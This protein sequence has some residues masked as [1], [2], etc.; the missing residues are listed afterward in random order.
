MK[1]I[2]KGM[3]LVIC[4]VIM[5]LISLPSFVDSSS[6]GVTINWNVSYP[7]TQ[8]TA[9]GGS[10]ISCYFPLNV[11]SGTYT[12]KVV[13]Y[14]NSPNATINSPSN[15]ATHSYVTY[16][17]YTLFFG[18]R[19]YDSY[20]T[21]QT[22]YIP[23]FN[24]WRCDT[25]GNTY[26]QLIP[27]INMGSTIVDFNNT[28]VFSIPANYGFI[29][30]TQVGYW[31]YYYAQGLVH[32][33]P[34]SG[35][36]IINYRYDDALPNSPGE[37]QITSNYGTKFT[38]YS[39][40][41]T[42]YDTFYYVNTPN[43]SLQWTPAIDGYVDFEG[44]SNYR[45][46]SGIN[47]YKVSL[48]NNVNPTNE[49]FTSGIETNINLTNQPLN[50]NKVFTIKV[51]ARDNEPLNWSGSTQ[52]YGA[53]STQTVG[54]LY[55]DPDSSPILPGSPV[56]TG[57]GKNING[58]TNS[59]NLAW[60]WNPPQNP[61]IGIKQYKYWI[62]A[63]PNNKGN[64]NITTDTTCTYTAPAD[65]TYYCDV[66]AVDYA[67]N[68]SQI[69]TGSVIVDTQVDPV[70]FN[71]YPVQLN[72]A[73]AELIWNPVSDGSGISKYEV[74][75][76]QTTA[77]PVS[78][79]YVS[80]SDLYNQWTYK[81]TDLSSTNTYYAWVRG[82][83][84][85][86]NTG[87]WTQTGPFPNFQFNG[88]ADNLQSTSCAQVFTVQPYSLIAGN[89][90][91]FWVCYYYGLNSGNPAK[92]GPFVSG[93]QTINFPSDGDWHWWLEVSEFK[94]GAEING[95]KQITESYQLSIDTTPP[96]KP[97]LDISP[98]VCAKNTEPTI[99]FSSN[100]SGSGLNHYELS[101]DSGEFSTVLSPYTLPAQ[102]EGIHNIKVR[103][104][105]NAGLTSVE[106]SATVVFDL[107]PPG[108][109]LQFQHTINNNQITIHWQGA[110]P[111]DDLLKFV[112]SYTPPFGIGTVKTDVN[113]IIRD[114]VKTGDFNIQLTGYA[115][116]QPVTIEVYSVD[117]AGNPSSTASYTA[118]TP[119]E[120][121]KLTFL[122]V[123]Y[124]PTTGHHLK[125][126]VDSTPGQAQSY[127]LEY[128][129]ITDGKFSVL[130]RVNSDSA[131]LI[132]HNALVD[133]SKLQPHAIY[134][135]RLVSYNNSGDPTY[136]IVFDQQV[137]NIAPNK[138]IIV[139][140]VY[141]GRSDTGFTYNPAADNDGDSNLI[142]TIFVGTGTNPTQFTDLK[143]WDRADFVQGQTYTWYVQVDDQHQDGITQSDRVQFTVDNNP[144]VLKVAEPH[145]PFTNQTQL[146]IA[147]SDDLSGI[148]QVTWQKID[149]I[150]NLQIATGT[151]DLTPGND[152]ALTGIIPLEQGNY[153]IL[154]TA[155]DKA[156]N[157]KLVQVNNLTV[158]QVKPVLTGLT[159]NLPQSGGKYISG[160]QK[161]PVVFSGSD[162]F[163]GIGALCYALVKDQSKPLA[164]GALVQLRAGFDNYN[165]RLE[166]NAQL[167]QEYYLAAAILDA[168]G[169]CSEVKYY[170]PILFDLTPPVVDL[171]L[172]GPVK[173][174]TSYY[175]ADLKNLN[176]GLQAGDP[177]TNLIRSQV[178][179]TD[180][181]KTMVTG[182]G[183]WEAI[184]QNTVLISG[185]KY[186]ITVRVENEAGLITQK[187]SPE[188][189]YDNT[190]PEVLSIQG[191]A[192]TV[193]SGEQTVIRIDAGD[194]ESGI[195][196]YR[197]AICLDAPIDYKLT[198]LIS[199]N[200]DGWI[201]IRPGV[202]PQE[203]RLELPTGASGDYYPIIQ[204]T[205][206]AGLT[207]FQ[208]GIK[209]TLIHTAEKIS[210]SDQGPYSMFTDRLSGAWKYLGTSQVTKYHYRITGPD[211]QGVTVWKTTTGTE[212]I[213][214]GLNLKSGTTY[215]FEV[216]AEFSDGSFSGSGFSPGVT[217]DTTTPEAA[218]LVTPECAT[219]DNLRFQ[220][221]GNDPESGIVLVQAALG[222]D[223]YQSD[224]TGGWVTLTGN[225][226]ML[227]CDIHGNTLRL[228]TGKRYYLTLRLTNGAGLTTETFNN[229]II[230]D[231]TPP[232]VPIVFDQGA[233]INPKQPLVAN[234]FWSPAD[235]ESGPDSYQWTLI[236]EGQELNTAVWR[237][238]D[239]SKRI[240]LTE[241]QAK[242]L[243][244]YLEAG[245]TPDGSTFYFAVRA[246]NRAG[247]TSTGI[248]NGIMADST[249]PYI[250]EVKLLNAVNLGDP[251]AAEVNYITDNQNLGLWIRSF[252][253]DTPIDQYL[254]AFGTPETID[255]Q[256]REESYGSQIQLQ[257]PPIHEEEITLFA[258]ECSNKA[259]LVSA[260]GYSSGVVLDTGAPKITNVHGGVSGNRLIFDWDVI[261]SVSPVAF[262]EVALVKSTDANSIPAAWTNIGLKRC[263]TVD[264]TNLADGK[265]CLLIR[266]TNEA[267]TVS[268]RQQDIDEWGISPVVML[269]RT[270][271]VIGDFSY[272][273]Y[274][275]NQLTL[276]ISATDNLAG[277][278]GYQ[279]TIGS[280]GDPF[281]YTGGWIA[282]NSQAGNL[283]YTIDTSLIAHNTS[284]YLMVRTIDKVGLWSKPVI[285]DKIIIDHIKPGI[286]DIT[287][288]QYCISQTDVNGIQITSQDPESGITHYRLGVVSQLGGPWLATQ[289]LPVS[290]FIGQLAGFTLNDGGVYYLAIQAQN[291]A[292]EWS[293]IGYSEAF[294]VDLTNPV[295]TFEKAGETI[296]TNGP[297]LRIQ[298]RLNKP[299][300]VDF[301]LTGANTHKTFTCQGQKDGNK[302][303][304]DE[305]I[306]D[307]SPGLYKLTGRPVAPSGRTGEVEQQ[308]IRVNSPPA[309]EI[310]NFYATPG[311]E[312]HIHAKVTDADGKVGGII[313]YTINPGHGTD[314]IQGEAILQQDAVNGPIYCQ[315]DGVHQYPNTLDPDGQRVYKAILSVSDEDE[316]TLSVTRDVIIQNTTHGKL[317]TDE[318]WFGVHRIN[319]DITVPP[320]I[321]LIVVPGTQVII[322]GIP[323]ETGYNHVLII[324]G[325]L[326]VQT[327]ATFKSITGTVENGWKGIY[328]TGQATLD[329]VN[330][331]HALRGI[332]VMNTA[333][334]MVNN[335]SF[336]D[337]Y[338]GIHV[339]GSK[340]RI[341][342][343]QFTNNQWYGIKEDRGGWPVVTH[344]GFT[345]NE[346]NYYQ[347]QVSEITI[348]DLNRIPGNGGNHDQD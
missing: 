11:N 275:S 257:D 222:S 327:G 8:F 329:G 102:T 48:Y 281:K 46:R 3:L 201:I 175:L 97:N 167:G 31:Y 100:D 347:D 176:I 54:V 127:A 348:D 223:Y 302:F 183:S 59:F 236:R 18:K 204:A 121:G 173:Y 335:C 212:A 80:N 70:T 199:G 15:I 219:S 146:T 323:G 178:A 340:P 303:I 41:G 333:N 84:N 103:A 337:N 273:K 159:V 61:I 75:I 19:S 143:Q 271:P 238:G 259:E 267:G 298:Y 180:S 339:Y 177:E 198:S 235:P 197:L 311:E 216:Q 33:Y 106:A 114:G 130:G 342:H 131:G 95:S 218:S 29:A 53:A 283:S 23:N 300:I 171:E 139:F 158:D 187:W 71:I 12:G 246:A 330:I 72:G 249:A 39:Y 32:N 116:N 172:T 156:N 90:L 155:Y 22:G 1:H 30:K 322:D 160:S 312:L 227:T 179:I 17:R 266:A 243:F 226:L 326:T 34:F 320:G 220:W 184:K 57:N 189:I 182:W 307:L 202:N 319:G 140:P 161:V 181:N 239:D 51:A 191:P 136:G 98:A 82:I 206:G 188:F 150:T 296:V 287:C 44:N 190:P 133:G 213:V 28:G 109:P 211:Q 260:T 162:S 152:G 245:L 274:T 27:Q 252:D 328:I 128:G 164:D 214:T 301:A 56:G 233:Y 86:D 91:R 7:D 132:V 5:L 291:G 52:G 118:Y 254:Y 2:F 153:H 92:Q 101:I 290:E 163:S 299:A 310:S 293:E 313:K 336:T 231:D 110:I 279:Y 135:Y 120:L 232:S 341:D 89:E 221:T 25:S 99:R 43:I 250:P 334:V 295:L 38:N 45:M 185:T 142:Y 166:I 125:W 113:P 73:V 244:P 60:S 138:P 306:W 344:C 117:E 317:W 203:I 67:G 230:I 26:D 129:N 237:D 81:F 224:V 9:S 68:E 24:I 122:G 286:P 55:I 217:I 247:L 272:D 4:I 115:F 282:I 66:A 93:S 332:T 186:L 62:Y 264:G 50:Q 265:Y 240:E 205:N 96:E 229:G 134:Y 288:G 78:G 144:P 314:L 242:E 79:K 16:S 64:C 148:D 256:I 255:T 316:G 47:K 234:W 77:E 85:L 76:T 104:I 87:N 69:K 196:E 65:G 277:I 10:I 193:T 331:Y 63:T 284:I 228:E 112:A 147:A 315:I 37:P 261:P 294:T 289:T 111:D 268:R 124:D 107:T 119:A 94:N 151:I 123:T 225:N 262:Y 318:I 215:W 174:G 83:D 207:T 154:I 345:G 14:R 324:E 208:S 40:N 210:V 169:N 74:A 263:I 168:A 209:F 108:V 285:S 192:G 58:C 42:T 141:Y 21:Y 308:D 170:G 251:N 36:Y 157:N 137:P 325:S 149:A 195:Q 343:C 126:Q 49:Y 35:Y 346:V 200:Q 105:D 276:Q 297:P 253:P 270:L 145:R 241:A 321:N 88:P 194:L 6:N 248:S 280:L 278:N 305:T 165:Y 269:D 304:I 13:D 20:G 292:G 309:I 338:I 258:G